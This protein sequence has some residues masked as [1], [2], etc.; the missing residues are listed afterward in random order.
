MEPS[1]CHPSATNKTIRRCRGP[2]I[3][4]WR[5]RMREATNAQRYIN[6][7]ARLMR[8]FVADLE[9]SWLLWRPSRPDLLMVLPLK[10]SLQASQ[11]RGRKT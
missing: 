4:S 8:V 10:P 6:E 3:P 5:D 2:G 1:G 9:P 11:I 7:P